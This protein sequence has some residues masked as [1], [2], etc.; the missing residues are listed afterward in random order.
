MRATKL[1][2]LAK[3]F[4]YGEGFYEEICTL[5]FSSQNRYFTSTASLS[6]SFAT[7]GCLWPSWDRAHTSLDNVL[8][9]EAW[10]LAYAYV[11]CRSNTAIEISIPEGRTTDCTIAYMPWYMI[12]FVKPETLPDSYVVSLPE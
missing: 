3:E 10:D 1:Q 8:K 12:S 2:N 11:F 6:Y 9:V 5:S 4:A 7:R